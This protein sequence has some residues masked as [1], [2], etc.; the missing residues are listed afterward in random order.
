MH[1][2]TVYVKEGLLSARELFLENSA[3]SYFFFLY[4]SLSLSFCRV[5]YS[6]LSNID[7]VLSINP[8][9]NVFVFGNFN[10][11]NKDWLT[12]SG[13]TDLVNPVTISL[14]QITLIRW[15]TFLLRFQTVIL[16]VLLFWIYFF[17]LML[18]FVLQ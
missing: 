9:A 1:C 12:Y 17:L 11:H 6:T 5:F 16:I 7:E 3:V 4:Q 13:G 10:V 18:V 2:L 15:L 14:S 8:S